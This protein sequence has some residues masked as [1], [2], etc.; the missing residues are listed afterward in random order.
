MGLE[1]LVGTVRPHGRLLRAHSPLSALVTVIKPA[2]RILFSLRRFK[3]RL[4]GQPLA[5]GR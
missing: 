1:V 3:Q 4:E 2:T 5:A